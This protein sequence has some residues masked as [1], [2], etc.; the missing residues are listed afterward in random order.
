MTKYE[1]RIATDEDAIS[2]ALRMRQADVDEVWASHHMA[3]LQALRA[4]MAGS[5]DTRVGTA[6]GFVI[7]MFGVGGGTILVNSG[8]PWMLSSVELPEHAMRFLAGSRE[9]I[10]E[11]YSKYDYLANHV[12][13]RN[14]LSIRW[15]KWLGFTVREPKPF[16]IDE[17]PFCRFELI[18]GEMPTGAGRHLVPPMRIQGVQPCQ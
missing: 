9:V 4:S 14:T 3:P 17:R 12:D 13:A 11:M 6:D 2:L 16:G 8:T 10:D 15:L 1:M 5:R 7:C 18:R